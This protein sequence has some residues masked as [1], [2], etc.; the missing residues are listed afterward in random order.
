MKLLKSVNKRLINQWVKKP[1]DLALDAS[2][3]R[4]VGR[5]IWFCIRTKMV[6]RKKDC[7]KVH[8]A[9]SLCSLLITDLITDFAITN[10]KRNDSPVLRILLKH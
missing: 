9:A 8:I 6:I 2:G 7:E 4:L 10:S 1:V 5:S 3:I